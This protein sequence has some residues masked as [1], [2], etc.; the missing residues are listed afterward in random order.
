LA[1]G[2]TRGK[3]APFPPHGA[4][5][6]GPGKPPHRTPSGRRRREPAEPR[7]EQPDGTVPPAN[8]QPKRS[9]PLTAARR[10]ETLPTRVASPRR[11]APRHQ[12][13]PPARHRQTRRRSN[14]VPFR[15]QQANVRQ[16]A[17]GS[18]AYQT[19]IR[20]ASAFPGTSGPA[21]AMSHHQH[22]EQAADPR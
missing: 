7:H 6:A 22:G 20:P 2:H 15:R 10:P 13:E 9:H 1:A 5:L 11:N 4:P 18:R 17:A 8:G 12:V 3:T 19:P 16:V 14:D 21:V